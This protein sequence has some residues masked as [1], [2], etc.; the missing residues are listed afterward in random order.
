[1]R[2]AV[3]MA[4][5]VTMGLGLAVRAAVCTAVVAWEGTVVARVVVA[6]S[7]ALVVMAAAATEEGST[8]AAA[9]AAG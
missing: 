1:M 5:A 4:A 7:A 3:A 8:A 9:A 2:T 6:D